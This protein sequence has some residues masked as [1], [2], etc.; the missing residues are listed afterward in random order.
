MADGTALACREPALEERMSS[1]VRAAEEERSGE[2]NDRP[3]PGETHSV[4]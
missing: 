3:L 1:T 2:E 4:I